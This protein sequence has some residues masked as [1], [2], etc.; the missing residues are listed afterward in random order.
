[1]YLF[2]IYI[3]VSIV[4]CQHN[5]W[6]EISCLTN[7]LRFAK[8]VSISKCCRIPKTEA[9][10]KNPVKGFTHTCI[11]LN[12]NW[13][14]T[15]TKEEEILISRRYSKNKNVLLYCSYISESSWETLCRT[16]ITISGKLPVGPQAIPWTIIHYDDVI[17]TTIASQITS[18][19]SVYSTV[20]SD[21]DQRKHQSSASL[22]FVWGIHRDRWIPRTKGQ[23]RG[24][25]FHLMT[26][27][28][29]IWISHVG[30]KRQWLNGVTGCEIQVMES[31]PGI[32]AM[33]NRGYC[34]GDHPEYCRHN[35]NILFFISRGLF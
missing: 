11:H 28:C 26:S 18:R 4:H 9:L 5:M 14:C 33:S 23:L 7:S 10:T 17:M 16:W 34:L 30:M 29:R 25:C 13:L 21:P 12:F 20:Y 19:T 31:F 32:W 22:A 8:I 6:K 15:G 27:S 1:M 24:K 3:Y 35:S 2:Q